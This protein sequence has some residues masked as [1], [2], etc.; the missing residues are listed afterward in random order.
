VGQQL[1]IPRA[2]TTLLAAR[3]ENPAPETVLAE[4]RPPVV[5]K[6]VVSQKPAVVSTPSDSGEPQRIVHR[7]KRGD[8]LSSIARL[9][10]T[11]V[12]SLRSWNT[13][14]IRG[15]QINVGDRLTIFASRTAN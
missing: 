12:A 1:I 3:P 15:S 13:R 2:P 10:N 6:P 9:Y 11:T 7:V 8:T 14:T 4:S 5:S